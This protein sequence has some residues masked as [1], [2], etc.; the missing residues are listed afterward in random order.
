MFMRHQRIKIYV[1]KDS[2]YEELEHVSDKFLK[3]RAIAI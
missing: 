3:Y 2:F 1:V